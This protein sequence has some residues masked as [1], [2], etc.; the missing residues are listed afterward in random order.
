M[1]KQRLKILT[2]CS[3]FPNDNNPTLGN[4]VKKHAESASRYNDVV[5]LSIFPSVLDKKIR[6]MES[7]N[8][9][10]S[11]IIVYY[12]KTTSK[13]RL[14]NFI[15]N[16]IFYCEAF[17]K[18][19]KAAG[20]IFGKPDLV[21]LNI[22]Y[23]I[24]IWALYLKWRH[25]IPFVVTENATGLHI[26]TDH[27]YPKIIL[28]FCKFILKRAD[29][30]LPV[31]QDLQKY[32]QALSPKSRFSIISN[33]VDEEVFKFKD[34]QVIDKK[35]FVHI[36][37]GKD[38][39]KNISGMLSCFS[40]ISKY[41]KDFHLNIV[42]DGD[43]EYAK[44]SVNILGIQDFV[45]FYPKLSTS[46]IATMIERNSALLLFSNYENFPCVIAET[47]MMGKPVISTNVNGIPE[48]VNSKNGILISKGDE[49]QLEKAICDFLDAKYMFNPIDIHAYAFN[50]FSYQEVGRKFDEQYRAVLNSR[51]KS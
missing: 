15:M 32:M 31:S 30:L 6:L 16:F 13:F 48:H 24:G 42:S 10:F 27:S 17:K 9:S 36:S 26:G 37:T 44:Y 2:L 50:H 18:G 41:R 28:F 21:H 35:S 14:W 43:V 45:T 5:C 22:T 40:Q 33:V 12:P 20:Y 46:E 11:E 25:K 3:W 4:F 7:G 23:P 49:K 38:E 47:L 34:N 51:I 1:I 8:G 29:V 19:Y 39:H